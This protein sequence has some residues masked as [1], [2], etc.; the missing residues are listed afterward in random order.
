[1]LTE[2]A[3]QGKI[4]TLQGLKENVIVGRLI[5]AGTGAG[6]NRMR[7]TASTRDLALR[8]EQKKMQ[9][10]LLAAQTAA[11]EHEAELRQEPEATTG[12]D[13]LAAIVADGEN[14]GET[15]ETNA[16][17]DVVAEANELPAADAADDTLA[18]VEEPE[19]QAEEKTGE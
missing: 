2:A 1:M 7:V 6:M 15:P 10:A 9:E 19:E 3:V 14:A 18:K 13:P 16:V 17:E 12:D 4:D 8:A 11:A 5:P